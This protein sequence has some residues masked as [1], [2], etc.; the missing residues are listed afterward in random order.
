MA[1]LAP[2][3]LLKLLNGLNTGVKPTSEHRSSLLQVTDIVP[4]DLDEKNLIP[5]QGFY[6][7]VSDSSHS[8]YASLPSDQDDVVL[9]N[10]MQLGQFIYV[11][12][13]EPGSPVPVLKGAKPLPGR[14]PL[15]G[16]PEPL[17]G[18]RDQNQNQNQNQ[19][20]NSAPRRGSWG[21]SCDGGFNFK[22]V[23]LDFEQCTPVKVRNGGFQPVSSSPLIR[24]KVGREGTTPGSGVRSSVGGGLLA[25]ISDAKVESPALLRKSCVVA[26]S[27][28]KFTRS[29][30]VSEREHRIPA[31]PFKSAEKKSGTPPPRLRNARVITPSSSSSFSSGDA[32]GHNTDTSV[33]SQPQSQSTTNSAF[34]NC[35]NLSLPMN[36]PGKL[37]SLGKEAMQQ[38]EVAQK[39]ALQALRDASATE[40][41]V[42]SLK[43]FSNL[44]KSARTDAPL[45]CFERFLEFHN[46]IVQ[47]VN[48]MVSIQAATSASELAQK[49]DKP[50][51]QVLHEVMDN[52]ENSESNMS[53]R[54]GALYKSMAA[55][56]EK[57]EQKANMGRLLRTS[58]NQKEILQK[59]GSTPLTK[60]PLE[61]IVENDENKKP[62]GSCSLSNTIKLGKQIETEA[63]NWFMEFIEK[64]LETG[65]KKTK[66]ASDGDVRKVPQSLILKVMNWVEVEQ[67][68]SNK[69]PS[70]PKAAQIARKLRIKMK[71]P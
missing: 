51:L 12:R 37:S 3:I 20:L 41:V 46:E 17:M 48:E 21:T 70:H 23:N 30:S 22:P 40:T 36:L 56:P 53:K 32:Q 35:N 15:V 8:I 27:N 18:L 29:R 26:T 7:K 44:C 2:G 43:M 13:L 60:M 63:G 24:G 64:A 10:K 31:S 61:P 34:D 39:I 5:K 69:R 67:C 71:N 45:A 65:L 58:T 28:S 59:K 66:D 50:E 1:T 57:H 25:K 54:R 68:Q 49:S 62:G 9:S 52:C 38:R 47:A 33:A 42:R 16:T 4:A 14:H 19:K 6:I 11:D 55:I